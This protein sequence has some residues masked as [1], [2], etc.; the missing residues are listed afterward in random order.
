MHRMPIS[1]LIAVT[2]WTGSV[3][4]APTE[5]FTRGIEAF[6]KNDFTESRQRFLE[7]L[8]DHP[9]DP[10]LLYNLGL[11]ELSDKHPGR[12]KAYWRK[13]LYLDP[14]ASAPLAGLS[15]LK[16]LVPSDEDSALMAL[17]R[18][19]PFPILAGFAWICFTLGTFLFIRFRKKQKAGTPS[20]WASWGTALGFFALFTFL[21]IHNFFSLH[22]SLQGVIMDSSVPARSSPTDEA[23]TLF[24]FREGDDVVVHRRQQDWLQVQKSATA[25]GWVKKTQVFI[26][27]G[28]S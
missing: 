6:Q 15:K 14:G 19:V 1:L 3:F 27:S 12:A 10:T 28:G 13:A 23:P 5:V 11:V 2:L 17:H 7:L 22:W 26:H 16:K 25:I 18:R 21:S 9:N 4:A 24:E 8:A 20:G